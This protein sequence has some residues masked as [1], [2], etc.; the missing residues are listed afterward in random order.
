MSVLIVAHP[1]M[2]RD[3][4]SGLLSAMPEI[5]VVSVTASLD[6]ALASAA[7][8]CPRIVL[9]ES[10]GLGAGYLAQV[11]ALKVLC[12]ETRIIALVED[13]KEACTCEEGAV[14]AALTKGVRPSRIV[15]T[16]SGLLESASRAPARA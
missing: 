15:E 16:V 10:S 2:L 11:Q 6:S 5:E 3:G 13:L 4:L 14:D 9:L 1:G 7:K 8:S 12:P